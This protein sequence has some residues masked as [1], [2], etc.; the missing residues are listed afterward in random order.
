MGDA[1]KQLKGIIR[2]ADT[3]R[4]DQAYSREQLENMVRSRRERVASAKLVLAEMLSRGAEL[5]V[6]RSPILGSAELVRR[7]PGIEKYWPRWGHWGRPGQAETPARCRI[8]IV[9]F[10]AMV[11]GHFKKRMISPPHSCHKN[12]I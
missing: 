1:H 11:P 2:S 8:H 4:T 10:S 12:P 5:E 9:S 6:S 7:W 3:S